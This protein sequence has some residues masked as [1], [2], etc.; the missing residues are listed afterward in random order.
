V[1]EHATRAKDVS[2][3]VITAIPGDPMPAEPDLDAL[4]ELYDRF[5]EAVGHP[6]KPGGGAG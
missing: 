3:F 6:N 1:N 2:P 5:Y 4:E